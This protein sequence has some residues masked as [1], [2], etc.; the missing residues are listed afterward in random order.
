MSTQNPQMVEV[1]TDTPIKAPPAPTN[2]SELAQLLKAAGDPLRLEILR[3]LATDSFGVLELSHVF[4][5]KQSGM[6]HH[7]K[8]LAK[9]GLVTTRREGNSI[10][11]R[12]NY[13]AIGDEDS[14][15]VRE[16][17]NSVD[18]VTLDPQTR[19]RIA[20]INKQRAE[21][22]KAFFTD[23]NPRKFRE[24]QDLIAAFDVYGP[25]ISE[26]LDKVHFSSRA[27]AL[28]IGPGEGEFLPALSARFK[29]VVALD[30]S[31]TMLQKASAFCEHDG[32]QNIEF[33]HDDTGYCLT[34][35]ARFD[36]VVINMVLHH[37]PSPARIFA[38]VSRALTEQGHLIICE[39]CGH[40][41][42]WAREACGDVWLGFD[43]ADLAYWAGEN[44]LSETQSSYFA[45]RNGFQIQI[46]QFTYNPNTPI[47]RLYKG[48]IRP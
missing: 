3:A 27:R 8:V 7:L 11:Y 25:Q 43:P 6:S 24:Q 37:T 20:E 5:I 1:P 47:N 40:D 38:D 12:R 4:D 33:I 35:P 42:D 36:C 13:P 21:T 39:L 23:H 48:A 16:L 32:L 18:R 14:A 2:A 9:A 45:L 26:L 19:Q 31:L 44:K 34:Q 15:V 28:E 30:N 29:N 41:Q 17:F 46:R 10:F 22:S